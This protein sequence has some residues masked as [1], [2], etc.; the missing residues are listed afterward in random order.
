MGW[1]IMADVPPLEA[2]VSDEE[3]EDDEGDADATTPNKEYQYASRQPD[4]RQATI[5]SYNVFCPTCAPLEEGGEAGAAEEAVA[6]PRRGQSEY[7]EAVRTQLPLA[8][9]ATMEA[10]DPGISL[11]TLSYADGGTSVFAEGEEVLDDVTLLSVHLGIVYLGQAGRVEYLPLGDDVPPPKPKVPQ[12][13]AEDEKEPTKS[14]VELDGASDAIACNGNSCT[15]E[16]RF[17][18][19]LLASPAQ[20]ATQAT[21]RPYDKQGLQGFQLQRVRK[22]TIP[23]MLGFRSSDVIKSINGQDIRSVDE[24]M[25]LFGRLRSASHLSIDFVHGVKGKRYEKRLEIDII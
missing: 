9:V 25:R 20:L 23:R 3:P 12:P 6:G 19:Q 16:R 4:A 5:T 8:L 15:V 17:V 22:G 21:V 13:A 2:R 18:E 24:A 7:P 11:A 10:D 14:K 1:Q